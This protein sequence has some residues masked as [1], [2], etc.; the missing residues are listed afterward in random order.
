MKHITREDYLRD[1]SRGF[2]DLMVLDSC[3]HDM[4][5]KEAM[6]IVDKFI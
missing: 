2:M 3:A 6:Y 5:L 4:Y 1:P